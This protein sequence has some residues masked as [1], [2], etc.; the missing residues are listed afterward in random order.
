M[1]LW[2][3]LSFPA[4]LLGPLLGSILGILAWL[5][6]CRLVY[7]SISTTTLAAN[8]SSMAG[9]VVSVGVGAVVSIGLSLWRP[10]NYDFSGTRASK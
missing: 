3:K 9:S 7:G 5:V 8:L 2:P 1:V 4:I 6:T 10:D